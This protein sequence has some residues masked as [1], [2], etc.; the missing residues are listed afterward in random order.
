[1]RAFLQGDNNMSFFENYTLPEALSVF[2]IYAFIGWCTEVVYA[3]LRHG[4]FVNRGFMIGPVC[5]IYGLGVLSVVMFLEPIKDYWGLLFIASML[6]TSLIEL[7]GGFILERLFNEKWW[8]YSE[9][10]F[11]LKGYICL[12]FSIMW[13]VACVLVIDVV[14]PSIMAVVR[15]IPQGIL[16]LALIVCSA[17][18]AADI[19]VT[20]I[21]VMKIRRYIRSS[22]EIR[23][24]LEH[25]SEKIGES[26][27]DKTLEA[28]E[29]SEQLKEKLTEKEQQMK[30]TLD[31]KRAEYEQLKENFRQYSKE[32]VRISR[33]IRKAFPHIEEGRFGE[34]FK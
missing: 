32:A 18:F 1:M 20:M 25:I 33:R 22:E 24:A 14:H 34:L 19:T 7:I 8:D 12:K 9:E 16:I 17:V 29:H 4:K 2:F 23:N 15:L 21:N 26:L 30:E 11:N 27:S 3:T 10:P 6:F 13:G 31:G 5:P 28:M